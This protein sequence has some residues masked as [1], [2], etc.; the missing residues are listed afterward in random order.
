MKHNQKT[1]KALAIV[2]SIAMIMSLTAVSSVTAFAADTSKNSS[3]YSITDATAFVFTD[4]GITVTEG[5]YSGYKIEGTALTIK[6][7]GTYV[8][9]GACANGT[10]VVKKNVTGVT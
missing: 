9:S 6:E 2:I 3:T 5:A 8:V 7:S 4:S 10:I 1:R